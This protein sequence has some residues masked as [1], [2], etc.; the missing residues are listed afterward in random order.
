[1]P[2]APAPS[3]LADPAFLRYWA[4]QA[5][6][7]FGDAFAFVAYPL[8]VLDATGSVAAMGTVSAASALTH[9]VTGVVAGP[10]VDNSD[11]R[12][13]M[14]GCDLGR[15]FVYGMVPLL[16][17][18]RGPSLPVL[19]VTTV[20]GSALGNLFG[21]AYVTATPD[22]VDRAR[23]TEANGRLQ[24]S[25]GLAFVVGPILAG[26]VAAKVGSVWAIGIDAMTFGL[27]AFSLASLRLRREGKAKDHAGSASVFEGVTFLRRE[28]MLR[29]VTLIFV[30]LAVLSS[31]TIAAGILDVLIFHLRNV[32]GA[33][34]RTV[35]LALGL[36]AVGAVVGALSAARLRRRFGF[37]ACFLGATVVQGV[38]LLSMGVVGHVAVLG[39]GA[40]LWTAG[41]SVRGVV[42]QTLRQELTPEALLGRVTAAFWTVAAVLAPV[43]AALITAIAARW[44]TVAAFRIAGVGV[45]GV[46]AFAASQLLPLSAAET[47]R[48]HAP[49]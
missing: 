38:A 16:W 28:P 44:G 23:L 2:P 11:R 9:L 29:A 7:A 14:I 31:G 20:I 22:L 33:G 39:L 5:I 6:S 3:L 25:Q 35:G 42:T 37:V 32:L 40:G 19:Y 24:G 21:V 30:L 34:D 13:L 17:W 18:W 41:M 1:M 45:L 12:R 36:G 27:S 46:A 26:M 10:I 4:G 15:L 43:G 8:L 49:R 47:G 48:S